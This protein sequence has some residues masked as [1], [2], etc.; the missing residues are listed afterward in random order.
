MSFVKLRQKLKSKLEGIDSIQEVQDF[1]SEEFGGF[2]VAMISDEIRSESEF[3]T[4]TEN[5]RNYI[6]IIYLI[7]EIETKGQRQATIIIE[8]LVDEV[9]DALDK[10]QTLMGVDLG[11]GKT[12]I[13]MRPSL[14]EFYNTDKYVIAKLEIS[15]LVQFDTES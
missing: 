15:I 13:I 1:P 4:T 12:M 14:S 10:D 8:S 7:Q 5:K 11:T 2:P 3:Q 9:M 6:F